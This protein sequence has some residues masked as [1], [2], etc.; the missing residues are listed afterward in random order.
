MKNLVFIIAL[1][2]ALASFVAVKASENESLAIATLNEQGIT[3]LPAFLN[4][5]ETIVNKT[6]NFLGSNDTNACEWLKK[7]QQD[8]T[9]G[10]NKNNIVTKVNLTKYILNQTHD[11]SSLL[12]QIINTDY[13]NL[14]INKHDL[15]KNRNYALIEQ[16]S[17]LNQIK[18]IHNAILQPNDDRFIQ[19]LQQEKQ[20]EIKQ[21]LEQAQQT[22][23]LLQQLQGMFPTE[24]VQEGQQTEDNILL[25]TIKQKLEQ[26]QQS[27]QFLQQQQEN[28]SS[29][30]KSTPKKQ[31]SATKKHTIHIIK[32][33]SR[34]LYF[35]SF[36]SGIFVT[37]L[38]SYIMKFTP[39]N[40]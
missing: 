34:W 33:S 15:E 7:F 40:N 16:P 8:T 21:V 36:A 28:N 5:V 17:L 23:Q 14:I 39:R 29:T 11:I 27:E 20:N 18:F 25:N 31:K 26:I 38:F 2:T 22:E 1:S 30:I 12:Q 13:S 6:M 24:S 4:D 32:K 19:K 37:L 9:N 35:A 3:D 10:S